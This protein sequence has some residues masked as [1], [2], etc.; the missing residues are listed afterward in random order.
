MVVDEKAGS[1]SGI[2]PTFLTEFD[3]SSNLLKIAS[4]VEDSDHAAKTKKAKI[5][6]CS[7]NAYCVV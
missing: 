5:K 1:V 7:K 6:I 4:Y 2:F 3:G